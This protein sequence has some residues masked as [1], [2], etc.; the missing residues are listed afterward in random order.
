MSVYFLL[1]GKTEKPI[2]RNLLRILLPNYSQVNRPE[3]ALE[4]Q[5]YYLF[6][7]EGYPTDPKYLENAIKDVNEFKQYK[8]LLYC[9]DAEFLSIEDKIQD[10]QTRCLAG[11]EE[12][13]CAKLIFVTQNRCIETWLLG[14]RKAIQ[15]NIERKLC[16]NYIN[17]YDVCNKDPELMDKPDWCQIKSKNAVTRFHK[18]YL[19]AII[20]K[21][22]K[23]CPNEVQSKEFLSELINRIQDKPE[24]LQ[25]FQRLVNFC[26]SLQN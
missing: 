16:Q 5:N 24:H 20:P 25:S 22:S 9:T 23:S 3:E 14:N 17:F 13:Q 15:E 19:K 6:S 26:N 1:E 7:T 10:I 2:Y 8:Y 12:I 18:E 21:Y 4:N 11:R